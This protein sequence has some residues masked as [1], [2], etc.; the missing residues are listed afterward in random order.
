MGRGV[1]EREGGSGIAKTGSR[2]QKKMRNLKSERVGQ[3]GLG[4][5]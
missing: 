1:N 4:E 2:G 3:M 5:G